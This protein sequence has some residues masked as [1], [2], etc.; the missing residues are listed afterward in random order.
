MEE[1]KKRFPN[2]KAPIIE[3]NKETEYGWVVLNPEGLKLGK[4]TDIG[5][6]SLIQ[7]EGGVVIGEGVQIGPYVYIC[8]YDTERNIKGKIVIEKGVKIGAKAIILPKRDMVHYI[9]KN[10]KAGSVVY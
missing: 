10:I 6:Y 9:R 2:W 7:A 4:Y 3:H 8:S 5:R 1:Y